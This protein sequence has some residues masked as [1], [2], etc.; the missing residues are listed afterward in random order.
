[1]D[2]NTLRTLSTVFIVLAFAGVCWWALGKSR[3]SRFDEAARLPFDDD[4]QND[5]T[6]NSQNGHGDKQQ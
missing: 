1:M 5:K 4:L 3:K 2:I 6:L